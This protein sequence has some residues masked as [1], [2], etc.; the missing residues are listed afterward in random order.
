HGFIA[1]VFAHV[2]FDSLLM[3]LS[4]IFMG[5]VLNISAGLFWIVLP[6]IVGYVI[7]K[8]NPKQ[9]EKP[10]VTTPHPEVLQ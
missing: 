4:L 3:G 10:Y 5:D 1:V 6:A 8:M 2:I 9:K 7:Y